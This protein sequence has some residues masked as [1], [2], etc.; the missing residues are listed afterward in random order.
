MIDL[1]F[2]CLPG[3]DDGPRDW[4]EAVALCRAAA[5]DG[6]GT[7]VATPHVLR[8]IWIN[9]D[10]KHRSE[11]LLKLNTLLSGKPAFLAGCEYFFS[12]DA[13]ELWELGASGPLVGLNRGS[14]L[15]VEFPAN[16][17]PACAEAVFHE[18]SL[19][20]VTPV[21]AHP[22]RNIVFTRDVERLQSLVA[23]GAATQITAGSLVGEFGK[24]ARDACEE[25]F[26]LGLVHVVASDAHSV[27]R[28]PP[29]L[30]AARERVR[31]DWGSDAEVAFFETNPAAL[32]HSGSLA[33]SVR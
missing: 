29:R 4:N 14:A 6:T 2:H 13:V 23:R 33:G 30:S 8:E 15:L 7:I 32:V 5:A 27:A 24:I 17:V 12:S 11:L 28:R 18:F 26:R 20:G 21:I 1:H 25:F 31:R 22:E 9:D 16:H 3:I 10:P 19:L